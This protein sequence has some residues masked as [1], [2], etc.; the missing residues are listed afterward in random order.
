MQ[1][2]Y[3]N[4]FFHFL[5]FPYSLKKRSRILAVS[6]VAHILRM[7]VT[8]LMAEKSTKNDH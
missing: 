7:F 4:L 3:Q 5:S 2:V 1:R 8:P 6:G